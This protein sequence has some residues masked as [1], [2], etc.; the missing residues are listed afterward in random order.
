MRNISER[1][2]DFIYE[3][4]Q[5]KVLETDLVQARKCF[6]DY[7]G[8][9]VGG[10]KISKEKVKNYVES[11][12]GKYSVFGYSEKV[13]LNSAV[14]LNAYNSHVLELDDGHRVAMMHLA[15]PIFSGLLSVGE[16]NQ[17]TLREILK[18]AVIGY[19]VSI[20]LASAIQPSHK[21]KGFH[22]TGTCGTVGCALAIASLLKYNKKEMLNVLCAAATSAAGLLEAI[23]GKS[24]QKPYN[25]ANAANAGVNAALFGKYF[26]GPK[27]ILG[28]ERGFIKNMSDEYDM[29]LLIQKQNRMAI[30]GIYMKP[31]A[32][33]R[34]CHAPIEAALKLADEKEFNV[35]N[36]ESV[37]VDTY[38]LAVYGHEHKKIEGVNSAKMSIPYSVAAAL[39]HHKAGL[40]MFCQEMIYD[41][42]IIGLTNKV[43]VKEN[44]ELSKLVPNK[45]SAIVTVNYLDGTRETARVD[46]PK[47]EPENPIDKQE[48]SDKFYSLMNSVEID[49]TEMKKI[50]EFI[51]ETNNEN[52]EIESLFG[53]IS[54]AVS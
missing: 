37:V 17:C 14:M 53:I 41:E 5:N 35:K 29:N 24:E 16:K 19:E 25:I 36:I 40:E 38:D 3:L 10:A 33:C 7:I 21:K 34:H 2:V 54:D 43:M 50:W 9:T 51:W 15:A 12:E 6:A 47:G 28:G 11:N 18:S 45:R 13:S 27:D 44:E 20:R 26:C 42:K 4:A 46:Y 39:I 1:F 30:H 31:Y 8:V 22:A 48:L 23:T 32:A 49:K 52:L